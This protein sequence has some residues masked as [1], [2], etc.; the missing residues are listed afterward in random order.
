MFTIEMLPAFDGDCLW[1]EYGSADDP[2]RVLIDGGTLKTATALRTR[3]EEIKPPDRRKFELLIV[4]H[5]DSDHIAGVL[6]LLQDPPEGLSIKEAWF[7]AYPQ[8]APGML[9][10]KEGEFLAVHFEAEE[11]KRAGYWNGSFGGRACGT[12]AEGVL[13]TFAL[14]GDFKITVLGPGPAALAK[15]RKDWESV[16][17]EYFTPGDV[18][19]ATEALK[20]DKRYRPGYLGGPDVKALADSEFKQDASPANGSSIIVLAE[21]EKHRCLFAADTFPSTVVAAL[22]R[23]PDSNTRRINLSLVK[24]PHH[25]SMNNNSND[26]YK[27]LDCPKYLIST[28]GDR[29]E[30]PHPEGVARIL[31]N[32]RG[33]ADLYF[34]YRTDFNRIW[35]DAQACKDFDYTAHF[36]EE[37]Q[38]GIRI[39]L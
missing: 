24:V 18:K 7:N 6:K 22:R 27:M 11:R 5:V 8:L 14:D 28:N 25:G 13:P 20:K 10:P 36:P 39:A 32:K 35:A 9:G 37:D 21:Y 38:A 34:N 2:K 16:V 29:H 19:A 15:L 26:L 4:T 23:L 17:A 12:A 3:I 1:L 33:H 30:H 31:A